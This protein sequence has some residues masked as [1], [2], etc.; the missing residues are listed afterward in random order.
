MKQNYSNWNKV[1]LVEEEAKVDK[2]EERIRRKDTCTDKNST[3][4]KDAFQI[5]REML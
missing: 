5:N 4:D 1:E 3:Y 2:A